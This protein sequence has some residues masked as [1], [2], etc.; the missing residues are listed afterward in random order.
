MN[1][2]KNVKKALSLL[3]IAL[4]TSGCTA[5]LPESSS[6]NNAYVDMPVSEERPPEAPIGDYRENELSRATLYYMSVGSSRL[7]PL[8]K[9]L[10]PQTNQSPEERLVEELLKAPGTS[11]TASIFPDG[12]RLLY[13]ESSMGVVT[14]NLAS[15]V[16]DIRLTADM[17][18]GLSSTLTQLDNV[19]GVNILLEG[20]ALPFAGMPLGTV[21]IKNGDAESFTSMIADDSARLTGAGEGETRITRTATLYLPTLF[22]GYLAPETRQISLS[23][24]DGATRL[25]AELAAAPSTK[26]LMVGVPMSDGALIRP[27]DIT[28]M[29]NGERLQNVY[30]STEIVNLLDKGGV[31]RH[32]FLA[33]VTLTLTTFCPSIDGVRAFIGDDFVVTEV[34]DNEGRPMSFPSGIMKREHFEGKVGALVNVR[35]ADGNGQLKSESRALSLQ[36]STKT[37][38]LIK[39]LMNNPKTEG[40]SKA[41][42]DGVSDSDILGTY[43]GENEARISLSGELYGLCQSLT[44]EAEARLVYS[45]VNTLKDNTNISRVRIYINNTQTE[46]LAGTITLKSPLLP[47][48]G[49]NAN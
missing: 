1:R 20:R 29:E 16:K 32:D 41:F 33:S 40:L 17:I 19:N 44:P 24:L 36:D 49:M 48:P 8:N 3:L 35:F 45:I 43:I 21:S 37:R 9:I 31:T 22:D 30:F 47:N 38:A 34:Y 6:D 23:S 13:V 11:G 42:P 15:A 27:C 7:M 26:G 5:F 12:T 18:A 2:L 10:W 28:V 39:M 4:I 46:T 25:I 14:V